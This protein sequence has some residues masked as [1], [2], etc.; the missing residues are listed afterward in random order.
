MN[1]FQVRARALDMPDVSRNAGRSLLQ[2]SRIDGRLFNTLDRV[3]FDVADLFDAIELAPVCSVGLNRLLGGIDQNSILTTI[4][5]AEVLG[6]ATMP[7][8]VECWRRRKASS[9]L[10]DPTPVRGEQP[11]RGP[12]PTVRHAWLRSAFPAFFDGYGRPR[13]RIDGV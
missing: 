5:N 9:R 11:A 6:D 2:A 8:A 7:L 4:R 12:S 13:H 1:V 3:A 10:G